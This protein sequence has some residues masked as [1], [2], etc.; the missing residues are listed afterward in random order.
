MKPKKARK[1]RE[2]RHD[3]QSVAYVDSVTEDV[4]VFEI[5]F[6]DHRVSMKN[7]LAH[8]RKLSKFFSD[9]ALWIENK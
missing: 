5:W 7:K 4:Y 3:G 1:P 6:W 9:Y 2:V 8:A